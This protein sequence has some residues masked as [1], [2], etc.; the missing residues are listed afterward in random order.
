MPKPSIP[1][2]TLGDWSATLSDTNQQTAKSNS[3]DWIYSCLTPI[4]CCS[5]V[6]NYTHYSSGFQLWTGKLITT[7]LDNLHD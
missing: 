4:L 6:I 3:L 2:E 1:K 7:H 5:E